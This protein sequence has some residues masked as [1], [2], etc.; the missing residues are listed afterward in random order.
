ME[1][2]TLTMALLRS[3]D[4]PAQPSSCANLS[5]ARRHMYNQGKPVIGGPAFRLGVP[6]SSTP[7]HMG[8]P[9]GIAR[10]ALDEITGQAIEKARGV[11]PS[12]LP[13]RSWSLG[14]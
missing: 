1:V 6:A 11:P 8:I 7:F 9:L 3:L 2:A 10:R 4:P 5:R 12:S 14:A 13:L